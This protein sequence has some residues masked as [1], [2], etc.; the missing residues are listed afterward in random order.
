ME[1]SVFCMLE[2]H[3]FCDTAPPVPAQENEL[4]YKLLKAIILLYR[5][6]K[7]QGA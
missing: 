1:G 2:N 4:H 6:S 7:L 5:V 3:T